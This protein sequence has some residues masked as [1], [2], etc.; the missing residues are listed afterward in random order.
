M[1]N[2]HQKALHDIKTK[3]REYKKKISQQKLRE[4]QLNVQDKYHRLQ[5]QELKEQQNMIHS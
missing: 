4:C 1:K 3:E 5:N 2:D